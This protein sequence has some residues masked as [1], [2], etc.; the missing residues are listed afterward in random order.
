[1]HHLVLCSLSHYASVLTLFKLGW[2]LSGTINPL[3]AELNPICHLLALLAGATT[4]VVS[5]LRVKGYSRLGFTVLFV[6]RRY[7]A[8][9]YRKIPLIQQAQD[10]LGTG[11]LVNYQMV[12]VL[13]EIFTGNCL[14]LP[15][16]LTC[17]VITQYSI[18]IS[19]S[20]SSGS[21]TI[22]IGA[23]VYTKYSWQTSAWSHNLSL[24]F[25][26]FRHGSYFKFLCDCWSF[27]HHVASSTFFTHLWIFWSH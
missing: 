5:R 23:S 27:M 22:V 20:A 14:L 24:D 13:T 12:L 26:H 3:N 6:C 4:V 9:P 1:M 7:P 17:I 18:W 19:P 10:Q 2:F 11:L 25:C 8:L 16:Y 21:W 15:Q